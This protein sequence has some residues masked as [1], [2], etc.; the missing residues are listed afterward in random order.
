MPDT[1]HIPIFNSGLTRTD[2]DKDTIWV[3]NVF[4]QDF[5]VVYDMSTWETQKFIQVGIGSQEPANKGI[6]KQYERKSPF[7]GPGNSKEWDKSVIRDGECD[8]YDDV[9]NGGAHKNVPTD[10]M[11]LDECK[12]LAAAA[13][14]AGI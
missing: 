10:L 1:C 6:A 14:E 12:G 8:Q 2:Q 4:M 7:Y 5:Y 13:V 9:C 11:T 3:G